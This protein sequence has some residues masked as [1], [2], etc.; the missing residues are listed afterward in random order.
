MKYKVG[1]KVVVKVE[2]PKK[3]W[4]RILIKEPRLNSEIISKTFPIATI[5][6]YLQTYT[7]IIDDDMLGW[8][9]DGFHIV[10][11]GVD[12]KFLGKKF[13][14]IVDDLILKKV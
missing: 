8:I 13:Y 4:K 10:H 12:R 14:D 3:G 11:C 2:V 6:E 1:D 9:I 7:I 5:S